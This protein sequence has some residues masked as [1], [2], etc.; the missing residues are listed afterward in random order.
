MRSVHR[1]VSSQGENEIE[2][3]E[4]EIRDWFAEQLQRKD[5]GGKRFSQRQLASEIGVHQATVSRNA[6]RVQRGESFTAG[7]YESLR[8]F[9]IEQRLEDLEQRMDALMNAENLRLDA[10][11]REESERIRVLRLRQTQLLSK[12]YSKWYY[13]DGARVPL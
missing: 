12:W 7:F 5:P 2:V 8:D 1:V 9:L 4:T 11:C 3:S 10:E 13:N 6:R